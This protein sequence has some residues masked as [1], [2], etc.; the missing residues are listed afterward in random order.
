[1]ICSANKGRRIK[2]RFAVAAILASALTGEVIWPDRAMAQDLRLSLGAGTVSRAQVRPGMTLTVQTNIPYA[3]LVI[4]KT[5]VAD[6]VPLS[7]RSFYIQG[8]APGITNISL[9]NEDKKLLG[10][11]DVRVRQDFSDVNAAVRAAVPGAD[12]K[13]LNRNEKIVL[14]GMV[15]NASQQAAAIAAA[16]QFAEKDGQVIS[17]LGVTENQQVAL[18]VRVIEAS[19][20]VGRDLGV[21]VRAKGGTSLFGSGTGLSVNAEDGQAQT[22]LSDAT[23]G[24]RLASTNTPFGTLVAQVLEGAGVKVDVII[25][26]LEKKGLARRL[27]QPNLTTISGE[28]ASF[29]VGGEVPIPSS[30]GDNGT[31]GY[32]YKDYGVRLNFL[33]TVLGHGKINVRLESEVSE[34]DR[35]LVVNGFP[36]FSTRK[37]SSV[38]ELRDGQSF[39]MAGMLQ[40]VNER[41]VQQ[42][43]WLGQIPILGALFRSTSFQKRETDL[44]IVVTP[45]LVRPTSPGEAL[46]TPLD[47]TRPSNDA[48]LFAF[49]MLEVDKDMIRKF[50]DGVGAKGAYGHRIDLD[51]PDGAVVK[52]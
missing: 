25:D 45:Y 28:P 51:F 38:L 8:N 1:M 14:S 11:V 27:A 30:L 50:R 52:K 16:Q 20:S 43:P 34:I 36:A 13:V 9:F 47:N 41:D 46:R 23:S 32:V 18:Q 2:R 44:V 6:V 5:S 12:I 21:K 40:S 24:Q 29:T 42:L 35:S 31:V 22:F 17:S 37:A 4:G 15:A 39:A 26:A 3:D 49:G 7:D 33:P 19:R 10:I 48:E